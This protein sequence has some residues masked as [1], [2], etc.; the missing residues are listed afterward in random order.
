MRSR[1]RAAVAAAAEGDKAIASSRLGTTSRCAQTCTDGRDG[2]VPDPTDLLAP[3]VAL[4]YWFAGCAGRWAREREHQIGG[5]STV[6]T[7]TDTAVC[8]RPRP[9]LWV[10]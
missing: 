7:P 1:S 2:A 6:H 10:R 4:I 5:R 9:G 8:L 3:A